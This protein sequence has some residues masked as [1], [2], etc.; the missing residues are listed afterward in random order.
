MVGAKK[1]L[2]KKKKVSQALLS[3]QQIFGAVLLIFNIHLFRVLLLG[4]GILVIRW[5][6]CWEKYFILFFWSICD[7]VMRELLQVAEA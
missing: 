2:K 5:L 1:K 7:S 6:L 3:A 4:G